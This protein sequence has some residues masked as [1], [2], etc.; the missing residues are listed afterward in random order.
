MVGLNSSQ[1]R[2]F[3]I[4][5]VLLAIRH[6]VRQAMRQKKLAIHTNIVHAISSYFHFD[7][8]RVI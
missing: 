5:A 6:A 2:F 1:A 3:D 7:D 8:G 4:V